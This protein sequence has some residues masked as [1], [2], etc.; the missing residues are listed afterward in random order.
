MSLSV[1]NKDLYHW[2]VSSKMGSIAVENNT[3]DL[4]VFDVS[5]TSAENA[6]RLVQAA[7]DYGFLYISPNGTAFTENLIGSQFDLS[8]RFFASPLSEKQNYHVGTDNRGWL[9]MH[10]EILDPANSKKEFKEAFN[11]GEFRNGKPQQDMPPTFSND[12]AM[13]QLTTFEDACKKTCNMVL[14]LLGLGLELEDG[15]DWFSKRHG[16]PSGCVVRMLHYPSLPV[17]SPTP[18]SHNTNP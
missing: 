16:Q 14:D 18:P 12:D 2:L 13:K 11:I 8:K 6:K 17:V 10:N 4:P 1:G 3:I 5:D 7:I 15:T 9:G